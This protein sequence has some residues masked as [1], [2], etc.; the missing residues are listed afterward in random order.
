VDAGATK[1]LRISL[2]LRRVGIFAETVAQWFG[3][4]T[5]IGGLILAGLAR[6]YQTS[7]LISLDRYLAEVSLGIG[8]VAFGISLFLGMIVE[9]HFRS[10]KQQLADMRTLRT[11]FRNT[12][13]WA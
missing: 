4:T 13:A 5:A 11:R 1:I 9:K 10:L 6:M 8:F 12:E 2:N 7:G 3:L